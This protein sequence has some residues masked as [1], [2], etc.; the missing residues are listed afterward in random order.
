[1]NEFGKLIDAH[2][3]QFERTLPGTKEQVWEYL[4]DDHKRSLWFAGGPTDLVVNG[5]MELIFN[6][7]QFS[8]VTDPTPDKYQDYGDG[9]T[10]QA[11]IL[12]IQPPDLLVIEWEEGLIRFEL[13]DLYAN[14]VKL[15]LT[16]ERLQDAKEYRVGTFAGWHTHLNILEDRLS[17]HEVKGFW[18]VHMK[19]EEEYDKLL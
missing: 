8:E 19:L 10:S 6:N 9:F 15:T 5:K 11:T 4:V 3:L 12:E 16:H 17:G 7:S 1:M 2:T 13:E 14:R 18:K